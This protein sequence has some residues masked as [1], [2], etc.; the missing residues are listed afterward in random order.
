MTAEVVSSYAD[1]TEDGYEP[2]AARVRAGL[3][4]ECNADSPLFTTDAADLFAIFLDALPPNRRQYY[5]CHACRRFVDNF[6]G[7]VA[8]D[9][10]GEQHS[11]LWPRTAPGIFGNAVDAMARA[12]RR[13]NVNGVFLSSDRILGLPENASKKPPYQWR[14]LHAEQTRLFRHPILTPFQAMADRKQDRET[15]LRGLA[16]FPVEAAREA[17]RLLTSGQLYR[18][19]KAEGA[20]AWLLK[21]HEERAAASG[22]RQRE[23]LAWREAAVAPPG[24]C[25]PRTTVVGTLLEDIVAGLPFG[26][27]KRKWDGK[28]HPLQYQRPTT[29][30]EGNL[31]QAEAV[32]AKLG[33][34]GALRRRFA[35]LEDVAPHAIWL[36][37]TTT[38]A[39]A[40]TDGVFSHL[41][42]KAGGRL[43]VEPRALPATA[44]TWE[45]FQR[46]V[47]GDAAKVE[48]YTMSPGPYFA[49]ITAADPDAPP[50]LQW[51]S[52]ERRNP[53]SWYCYNGGSLATRWNL[54]DRQLVVVNAIVPNPAQW[55]GETKYTHHGESIALILNGARDTAWEA[56]RGG[57]FFPESLRSEFH[58]VRKAMEAYAREATIEG[59]DEASACGLVL[60]KGAGRWNAVRVR[61]TNGNDVREYDLDR[62]D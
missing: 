42:A 2:F 31:A 17:H 21:V 55:F 33:V 59:R 28:L 26:D 22:K 5:T 24:F 49:L 27:I 18:S 45:K 52:A 11:A 36:P 20:A 4:N 47:L 7:L 41:R 23:N 3:A 51:D 44:I 25:H 54:P 15:L 35:R 10:A 12:V 56:G 30:S 40:P 6:G 48:L 53:V 34:A 39:E 1:E 38:K 9:D 50:I 14:H 43:K 61:V 58:G 13:A 62:W 46:T 8:I 57:G 19:E 32:V 29:L 16:E 60:S 37:K